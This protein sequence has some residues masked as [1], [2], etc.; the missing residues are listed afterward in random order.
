MHTL[1]NVNK[2]NDYLV[3]AMYKSDNELSDIISFY[4]IA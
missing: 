3:N 2:L 4:N 1:S